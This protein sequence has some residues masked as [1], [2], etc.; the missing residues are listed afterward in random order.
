[1]STRLHR[2]PPN[3]YDSSFDRTKNKLATLKIYDDNHKSQ[4]WK[5]PIFSEEGGLEGLLYCEEAFLIGAQTLPLPEDQYIE[6]L[7]NKI[8]CPEAQHNKWWQETTRDKN[9]EL[10]YSEDIDG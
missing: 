5:I 1:M 7:T 10:N 8:L 9:H 3:T 6:A 4:E 2:E